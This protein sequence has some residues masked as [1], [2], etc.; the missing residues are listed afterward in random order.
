M[1]VSRESQNADPT[2]FPK[3]MSL[4]DACLLTLQTL[5]QV[6]EEKLDEHNVQLGVVTPRKTVD[7]RPSGQF[8]LLGE[9]EL[10]ALVDV[11]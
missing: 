11:M 9:S 4:H 1:A 5:K 2:L 8:R 10:K 3:D 7:G 6:M